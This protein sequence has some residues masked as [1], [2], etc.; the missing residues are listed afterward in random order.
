MRISGI[1]E[2]NKLC[3]R[4]PVLPVGDGA[5][6]LLRFEDGNSIGGQVDRAG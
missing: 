1:W 6:L 4:G 5:G 3:G 2:D